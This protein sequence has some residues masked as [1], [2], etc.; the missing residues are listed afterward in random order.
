VYHPTKQWAA[1][2]ADKSTI[3]RPAN[4]NHVTSSFSQRRRV[5]LPRSNG[6][7]R[8]RAYEPKMRAVFVD[9]QVKIA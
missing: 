3:H 7:P 4:A 9:V 1:D 2:E 8:A 6:S 5:N